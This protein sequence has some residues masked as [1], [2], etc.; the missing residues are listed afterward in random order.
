MPSKK[1]PEEKPEEK[2]EYENPVVLTRNSDVLEGINSLGLKVTKLNDD[3]DKERESRMLEKES[4]DSQTKWF[5]RFFYG[6][7]IG[8]AISL[9]AGVG[10]L[11]TARTVERNAKHERIRDQAALVGV[12]G[13]TNINRISTQNMLT[14]INVNHPF[15]LNSNW[16]SFYDKWFNQWTPVECRALV[17]SDLSVKLC[18]QYPPT[19]D[20]KTGKPT[21]TTEDP[22]NRKACK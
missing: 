14:D 15:V 3:V 6:T 8:I 4:R 21:P 16:P 20:Q 1:P 12:C 17:P 7:A 19:N 13:V 2:A 5:K 22:I 11:V 10:S 18:L 9:G